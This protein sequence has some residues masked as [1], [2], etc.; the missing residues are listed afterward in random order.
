[1][2]ALPG[3]KHS[4]E[5]IGRFAVARFKR[6]CEEHPKFM[7]EPAI[8]M[9]MVFDDLFNEAQQMPGWIQRTGMK[10]RAV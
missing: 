10:G 5:A 2:E 1:M 9:Q 4:G 7:D 8:V 3:D 6:R